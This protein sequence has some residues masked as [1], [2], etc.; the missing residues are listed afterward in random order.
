MCINVDDIFR[1]QQYDVDRWVPQTVGYNNYFHQI[2]AA[3]NPAWSEYIA[4]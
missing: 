1:A 3:R 4:E 2:S